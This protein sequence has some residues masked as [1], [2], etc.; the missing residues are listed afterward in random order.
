MKKN[1]IN[2]SIKRKKEITYL[3]ITQCAELYHF[4][5]KMNEEKTQSST[6]KN[7]NSNISFF[8]KNIEKSE[9][10]KELISQLLGYSTINDYGTNTIMPNQTTY[11]LAPLRTVAKK[12][13]KNKYKSIIAVN[14]LIPTESIK[15]YA[16]VI[17]EICKTTYNAYITSVDITASLTLTI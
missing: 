16:T 14:E 5:K 17:C 2:I 1:I 15:N 3:E 10:L 11:N 7:L 4:F 12:T 6:W 8:K 9:K 13:S